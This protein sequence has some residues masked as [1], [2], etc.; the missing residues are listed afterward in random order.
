MH[1]DSNNFQH[2]EKILSASVDNLVVQILL[3]LS[4]RSDKNCSSSTASP[5][6]ECSFVKN[7]F[8]SLK[9]ANLLL[10]CSTPKTVTFK[11]KYFL[12]TD[13]LHFIIEYLKY[14]SSKK[15]SIFF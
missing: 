1:S 6:A 3:K 14:T 9:F 13:L 11:I 2:I 8:E 12:V 4:S 5:V 10:R 15:R 7:A